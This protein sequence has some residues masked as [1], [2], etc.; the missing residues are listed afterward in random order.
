MTLEILIQFYVDWLLQDGQQD[1][2]KF[3]QVVNQTFSDDDYRQAFHR[4]LAGGLREVTTHGLSTTA[5]RT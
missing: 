4:L 5:T 1:F 3:I 2:D